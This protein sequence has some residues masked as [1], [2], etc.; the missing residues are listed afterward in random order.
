MMPKKGL[1]LGRG[2]GKAWLGLLGAALPALFVLALS[3]GSVP[4]GPGKVLRLLAEAFPGL[5]RRLPWP[6]D[7]LAAKIVLALRL[8][9]VLLSALAGMALA[10]AGLIFQ[11]V[12]RNPM[13]D[14]Y[15]LGTSAG[16]ALG[17]AAAYA[18][19]AEQ[20]FPGLGGVTLAALA[21]AILATGLAF[22]LARTGRGISLF[23]LLLNGLALS[24]LLSSALALLMIFR[25]HDAQYVMA[26]LMGSLSASR[27]PQV[28]LIL[29]CL[30]GGFV[31][32]LARA[33]ELN[34]LLL[35][36]ERAHHL[37]L[38]PGRLQWQLALAASLLVTA[39]VSTGGIIGFVGLVVP[40]AAR[41]LCG[42]D[43]RILI[44]LSTLAGGIFLLLADTAARTVLAPLE[45]PVGIVTALVGAP[46]FIYLLRRAGVRPR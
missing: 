44:P 22:S 37:G 34:A 23:V 13:A 10:L 6:Y 14:P 39:A 27:W 41:L 46:V 20:G 1:S 33:R 32:A 24:F 5:G 4:I 21:G 45:I 7:P 42:P 12:F 30:A 8:P 15:V 11:G 25:R 17:A 19:G 31:F 28:F 9:R 18:L 36:E 40:H 38:A 29:P 3:L 43:H 26:W 35:G 2:R 16:A